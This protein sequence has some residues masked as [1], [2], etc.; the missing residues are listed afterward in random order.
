ML[1]HSVFVLWPDTPR[2]YFQTPGT[3][4]RNL[5]HGFG[6]FVIKTLKLEVIAPVAYTKK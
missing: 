3:A 1:P 6:L 4:Q 2:R 5:V